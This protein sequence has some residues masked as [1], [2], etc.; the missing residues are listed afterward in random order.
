V[1][2]KQRARAKRPSTWFSAAGEL[3]ELLLHHP[4]ELMRGER[5]GKA[6]DGMSRRS[7]LSARKA[8]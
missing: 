4:V 3:S 5:A 7:F 6:M 2:N 1:T 8:A